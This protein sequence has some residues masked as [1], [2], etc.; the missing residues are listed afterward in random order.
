MGQV[1]SA[2]NNLLCAGLAGWGGSQRAPGLFGPRWSGVAAGRAGGGLRPPFGL[3]SGLLAAAVGG[4][5]RW[6]G[7]L[8]SVA[9]R[10]LSVM[11]FAD[12]Y[13]VI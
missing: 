6:V 12:I 11:L 9:V 2:S 13:W 1:M 8:A 7:A 10:V 4:P 3:W 5:L